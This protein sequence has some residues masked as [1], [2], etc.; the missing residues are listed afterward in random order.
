MITAPELFNQWAQDGRAEGMERGHFTRAEPALKAM[1][2]EAGHKCLDVGCGNG[3]ATRWMRRK[4]GPFGFAA[5]I[6]AAPEMIE[7]AKAQTREAGVQ[8]RRTEFT[9]LPWKEAFF[10]HAF[11]MEA[12]YYAP[13][14]AAALDAIAHVVKPG[15]TLSVVTDFYEENPHCHSWPTDVGVAMNLMDV[16]TW[17]AALEASG[18]AVKRTWRSLDPRPAD[19]S[20]SPERTTSEMHFRTEVGSLVLEGVRS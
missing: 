15:G 14:L 16:P 1:P 5:G 12:L 20:W 2:I 10:D 6:D 9:K 4:A 19:P 7:R 18:F 11:S 3:W 17:S 13:D 8:Y